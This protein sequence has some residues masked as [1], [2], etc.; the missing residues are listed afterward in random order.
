MD[1]SDEVRATRSQL[2]NLLTVDGKIW[3]L[4]SRSG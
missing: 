3:G 4:A 2:R 1:E